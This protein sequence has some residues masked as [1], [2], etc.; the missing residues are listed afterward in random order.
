MHFLE[1]AV[2]WQGQP[3]LAA[4]AASSR[5]VSHPG[6]LPQVCAPTGAALGCS[7]KCAP[8]GAAGSV[9]TREG[10]HRAVA[11][12]GHDSSICTAKGKQPPWGKALL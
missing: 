11:T 1:T 8:T 12:P 5:R 6:M 4:R 2:L 9:T 10:R 3:L 7:H